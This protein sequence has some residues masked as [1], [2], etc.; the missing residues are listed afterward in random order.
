MQDMLKGLDKAAEK[1][2]TDS[3]LN[4]ALNTQVILVLCPYIL[5]IVVPPSY[6]CLMVAVNNF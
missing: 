1:A 6:S 2:G 4:D 5:S 3:E